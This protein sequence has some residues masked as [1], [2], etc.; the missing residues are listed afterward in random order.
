MTYIFPS[1][2]FSVI[3][4]GMVGLFFGSFGLLCIIRP[5]FGNLSRAMG[6]VFIGSGLL[7]A[8]GELRLWSVV[9]FS[10]GVLITG[11]LVWCAV[12]C[13]RFQKR[14]LLSK[15]VGTSLAV[16]AVGAEYFSWQIWHHIP[17]K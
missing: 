9:A 6:V 13:F 4:A 12:E 2:G 17:M 3:T 1:D 16:L 14:R 5:K 15:A 10:L 11:G 8:T 7:Y